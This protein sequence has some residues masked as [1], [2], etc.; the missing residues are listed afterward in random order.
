VKNLDIPPV[1]TRVNVEFLVEGP[2][3]SR[4][5]NQR[6][7]LTVHDLTSGVGFF[8]LLLGR[9]APQDGLMRRIVCHDFAMAMVS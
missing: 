2:T 6:T 9:H 4:R 7:L 1:G 3:L 8:G 5:S